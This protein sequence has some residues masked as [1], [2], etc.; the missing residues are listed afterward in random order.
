M[1]RYRKLLKRA[2]KDDED[3]PM[4]DLV[5]PQFIEG[6]ARV[7]TFGAKKYGKGNWR[8]V[9]KERYLAALYRHVLAY[10]RGERLDRE[11]RLH[12]MLHAAANCMFIYAM[13]EV[14]GK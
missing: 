12:H 13:D 10:H 2:F 9:E 5:V 3:K 8:R 1:M 4:V 6:V 7:L 11:S 14:L